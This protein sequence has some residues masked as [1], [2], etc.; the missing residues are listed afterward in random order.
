MTKSQIIVKCQ[1]YLDDMSELSDQEFSDLFD[2]IYRHIN[3]SK[4]WEGTKKEFTATVNGLSTTLP[5]DFLYPTANANFT[6]ASYAASRPVVFVGS[7]NQAFE[8]VSW[9]DR[10]QYRNSTNRAYIDIGANA[11]KF[12]TPLSGQEVSMDYHSAMPVLTLTDSPWFPAEFHDAIYHLMAA[13]D[14]IIQQSEKG[15]SYQKENEMAAKKILDKMAFWNAQL[16][17]I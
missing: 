13:D 12:F 6:D 3:V 11:L 4:T 16:I 14:Y 9:S 7:S 1:L 8:I 2:K 17:Q 15:K 10:R 5:S